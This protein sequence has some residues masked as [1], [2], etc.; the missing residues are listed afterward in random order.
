MSPD[1]KIGS[2]FADTGEY[3]QCMPGSAAACLL[4]SANVPGEVATAAQWQA[5]APRLDI[6]GGPATRRQWRDGL[7]GGGYPLMRGLAE[8][9]RRPVGLV[10]R[11]RVMSCC[12]ALGLFGCECGGRQDLPPDAPEPHAEATLPAVDSSTGELMRAAGD[13][14]MLMLVLRDAGWTDLRDRVSPLFDKGWSRLTRQLVAAD[15][16]I[17]FLA[18]L[19]E[20]LDLELAA[21]AIRGRDPSRPI[22]VSM[23]EAPFDGPPGVAFSRTARTDDLLL[24][25]RHQIVIPATDTAALTASLHAW[26]AV[27]AHEC[28]ELVAGHTGA[29]GLEHPGAWPTKLFI[30]ILPGRSHVRVAVFERGRHVSAADVSPLLDIDDAQPPDTPAMRLTGDARHPI[31]VMLRPWQI[32]PYSAWSGVSDTQRALDVAGSGRLD[33]ARAAGF[34]IAVSAELLAMDDNAEF[35]DWSFA[36]RADDERVRVAAVASLTPVGQRA[37]QAGTAVAAARVPLAHPAPVRISGSVDAHAMLGVAEA[38]LFEDLP[39]LLRTASMCGDPCRAY[40]LLRSPLATANALARARPTRFPFVRANAIGADLALIEPDGYPSKWAVALTGASDEAFARTEALAL[41]DDFRPLHVSRPK[42]EGAPLLLVG[43]NIDPTDVFD[44]DGPPISRSE[45]ASLEAEANSLGI[46]SGMRGRLRFAGTALTGELVIGSDK[47]GFDFEPSFNGLEWASPTGPAPAPEAAACLREAILAFHGV[48]DLRN[49]ESPKRATDLLVDAVA[50]VACVERDPTLAPA[51]RQLGDTMAVLAAR[52]SIADLGLDRA[53]SIVVDRCE[54]AGGTG[55]ACEVA[56]ELRSVSVP[57]IATHSD[58]GGCWHPRGM[59]D[60][61]GLALLVQPGEMSL[62]GRR[63]GSTTADIVEALRDRMT[64]VERSRKDDPTDLPLVDLVVSPDTTFRELMPAIEAISALGV[65]A[66][67]VVRDAEGKRVAIPIGVGWPTSLKVDWEI[68][69]SFVGEEVPE[70]E[71]PPPGVDPFG[72]ETSGVYALRSPDEPPP[73]RTRPVDPDDAALALR[74]T[75]TDLTAKP[76][77]GR[78]TPVSGPAD[79]AELIE[80]ARQTRSPGNGP[81]LVVIAIAPDVPWSNV[82]PLL[83]A[84]CDFEPPPTLVPGKF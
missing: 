47:L 68:P 35:G 64:V 66:S 45:L 41:G 17:A 54:A 21:P 57:E 20:A 78:R 61:P 72:H 79:V 83:V 55:P 77:R 53:Q 9:A 75:K 27:G 11:L 3:V 49:E 48:W 84:T 43:K 12:V 73:P 31:A 26:L 24:P 67:V 19:A 46:A 16:P 15:G 56:E 44:M 8:R 42:R 76:R 69:A 71:P 6:D 38:D 40:L 5:S 80:R 59:N 34:S 25:L 30:A 50:R 81:P 62:F 4:D 65:E 13:K 36:A 32:R 22:V 33:E 14:G 51:A 82:V 28:P 58:V 2:A 37:W 60:V 10:G 7:R 39:D 29:I 52:L 23:F 1:S 18:A 74:L 70:E 63:V